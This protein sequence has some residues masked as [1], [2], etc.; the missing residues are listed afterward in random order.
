MGHALYGYEGECGN[1]HGHSYELHVT[2]ASTER[3]V[4]FLEAPGFI[5]DFREL[6]E[7]VRTSVTEEM[8]HALLL[9]GRYVEN[10]CQGMDRKSVVVLDAE[11]SAENLLLYIRRKLEAALPPDVWLRRLK[12][13]ETRDS[14]AEWENDR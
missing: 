8:D 10:R 1:I 2:V 14:Y 13:Y 5:L 4:Q 7:I 3:V 11:P 12:L 6:K 9:S